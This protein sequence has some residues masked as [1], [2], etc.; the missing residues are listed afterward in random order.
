LTLLLCHHVRTES[1]YL[2]VGVVRGLCDEHYV[3][4]EKNQPYAVD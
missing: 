4:G 1:N 2:A 3:R